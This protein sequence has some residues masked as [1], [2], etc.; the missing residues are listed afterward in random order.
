VNGEKWS[1]RQAYLIAAL[2]V[3]CIIGCSADQ[4]PQSSV[5]DAGSADT[6]APR[7][8][9]QP[10]V[11]A[12]HAVRLEIVSPSGRLSVGERVELEARLLDADGTS[13]S[14]AVDVEWSVDDAQIAAVD[15][16][17]RE[18]TALAA[19]H[20]VL[21]AS[22]EGLTDSVELQVEQTGAPR[23]DIVGNALTLTYPVQR[24][25]QIEAHDSQGNTVA[26]PSVRWESSDEAVVR[27]NNGLLT[28]I[29]EGDAVIN[30]TWRGVSDS[31]D[32]AVRRVG[33]ITIEPSS[34]ALLVGDELQLELHY[35]STDGRQLDPVDPQVQWSSRQ[36]HVAE[37]DS[38][39]LLR[40]VGGGKATIVALSEQEQATAT[41]QVDV[42]YKDISCFD[43]HCCMISAQDELYCW[44][45]N[46]LGQ[47]GVGDTRDRDYPTR[48]DS[49]AKFESVSTGA[50]AT[51]AID[52]SGKPWCWGS[53]SSGRLGT[54]RSQYDPIVRP[55]QVA[56]QQTLEQLIVHSDGTYALNTNGQLVAWGVW[57]PHYRPE[58]TATQYD[59][60][61]VVDQ[62]PIGK[63]EDV[64]SN[65]LC[66]RRGTQIQCIGDN[67]SLQMAQGEDAPLWIDHFVD[68]GAGL[69]MTEV[70]GE[71]TS[72]ICG[73][74]MAG[75]VWCAAD[76]NGN[77]GLGHPMTPT[78]GPSFYMPTRT[79]WTD[80]FDDLHRGRG[81][82]CGERQG[83]L[84]CWG[85]NWGCQLGPGANTE[86][87]PLTGDPYS[88][89][90]VLIELPHFSAVAIG[91]GYGCI[92]EEGSGILECWGLNTDPTYTPIAGRY[93]GACNPE[94]VQVRAYERP[95]A[96]P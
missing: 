24:Q 53:D 63:I 69:N 81:M 16:N 79:D 4:A 29:S 55:T 96:S 13:L 37:V 65:C 34:G 9:S 71:S 61:T 66:V 47:L 44:G 52:T 43:S 58:P 77:G 15:A 70:V 39:G 30:A 28:T 90:P 6:G 25:L 20:T 50:K 49:T 7:D 12:H 87:N 33:R 60:P 41:F 3:V 93:T 31:I 68:W 78:G 11:D 54:S 62:G 46:N 57:P 56:T 19:G 17:A 14:D 36:P 23:L 92:I 32:I 18:I 51:C 8:S 5:L 64:Q 35:F 82:Y 59:E 76:N 80:M 72:L 91:Q 40:A 27:I 89:K 42:R 88:Y 26:E 2:A 86:P 38:T 45:R 83:Q 84:W 73:R 21:H 94:V 10:D 22:A 85:P 95:G 48:V 1:G 74:D 67:T 75:D